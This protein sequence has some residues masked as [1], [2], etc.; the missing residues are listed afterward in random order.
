MKLATSDM[1]R[2]IDNY[3]QNVLGITIKELMK[4]S[5]EAVAAAIRE[6]APKDK[7]VVILAGKGN[8]GADGYAA[9][10]MLQNE[11]KVTVYDIFGMGQ[12]SAEGKEFRESYISGG[13]CVVAFAPTPEILAH[14][15]GAG[16][17]VDAVFGT[18]FHGEMPESIRPLAIT[19]RESVEAQK[20]A[21]DVPLGIDA[22]KGSVSEFAI[23]V[24][25]TV[26]LSFIKPGIISYPARSYVGKI[27]Y[28]DLGLPRDAIMSAFDFKYHLIDEKWVIA[29]L[30]PREANS[31]KGTF[32]KLLVITGST[33]YRGAAHLSVESALRGGELLDIPDLGD[34]P[35]D[36]ERLTFE[37]K[38]YYE[39]GP[40]NTKRP[41]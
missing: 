3:S 16:C 24:D 31:N 39:E 5:G 37:P 17:I 11:Y 40:E 12:K 27:I 38:D 7:D 23:T 2:E 21:I 19:I 36:W 29:N 4:K 10:T 33:K 25:A 1:I 18:G 30:P 13:G 41:F 14:I 15:K 6:R 34:A 26:E 20:I 32:G 28:D 22:D 9:A 8:N 35:A